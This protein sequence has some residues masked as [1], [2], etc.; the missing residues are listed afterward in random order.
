MEVLRHG[1]L[2]YGKAIH[3][4]GD[5][6]HKQAHPW[7]PTVHSLLRHLEAV[8]FSAAPRVVGNGLDADGNET[9][10]YVAG[11]I[12]DQSP[13]T[14]A[15]AFELGRLLKELHNAT[16]SYRPPANAIWRPW[17]GRDLGASPKVIGHCDVAPWNIV[18]RNGLPIA[19][20]DWDY[21]GPVDRHVDLAQACWLNAK[22]HDDIVARKEQLPPLS[23]RAKC[24]RAVV[25]GYGLPP[26]ERARMMGLMIEFAVHSAAG[27]AD[28][29]DILPD[30]EP[31]DADAT[32]LWAIA[33]RSRAA[34]WMLRN[35]RALEEALL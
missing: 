12:A 19:L 22:L 14:E 21:S 32:V 7:T 28:E 29:A 33:W 34:A 8:G 13:I 2:Y 4:I 26:I 3:R 16:G 24:L 10:S 15:A 25:D 30:R 9:L 35:R 27:E 1:G 17:Y 6:V 31:K 18:S 23:Q 11:D 20:I 5:V